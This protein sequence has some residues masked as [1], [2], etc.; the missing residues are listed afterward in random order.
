M[1]CSSV[2]ASAPNK[3]RGNKIAGSLFAKLAALIRRPRSP[4]PA[5]DLDM[6]KLQPG[7]VVGW[8]YTVR[9]LLNRGS[10]GATYRVRA[11]C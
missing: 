4:Q 3:R 2:Y 8:K 10:T 11:R 6:G 5:R 1:V 9:E 7:D